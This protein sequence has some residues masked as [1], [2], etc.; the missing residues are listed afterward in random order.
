MKLSQFIS[1][2]SQQIISEWE[3]FARSCLPAGATMDLKQ[4]RDHIEGMLKTIARDL[5][6]PQ[7]KG[8]QASKSKGQNDAPVE[9]V[10]T[11]IG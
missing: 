8:K 3:E 11:P 5:E 10:G 2:S 6:T 4:R 7:S 9:C 1:A